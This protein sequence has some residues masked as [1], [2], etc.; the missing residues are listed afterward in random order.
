MFL[1]SSLPVFVNTERHLKVVT[2]TVGKQGELGEAKIRSRRTR[3]NAE[4]ERWKIDRSVKRGR[5]AEPS[6]N[7]FT[8][9]FTYL[10]LILLV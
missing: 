4:D 10:K 3:L 1:F 5:G 2:N 6:T 9:S 8:F 7:C